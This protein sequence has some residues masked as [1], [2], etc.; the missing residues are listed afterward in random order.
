[1]ELYQYQ[2]RKCSHSFKRNFLILEDAPFACP[3]CGDIQAM[4]AL[5]YATLSPEIGIGR[6]DKRS[7]WGP[8]TELTSKSAGDNAR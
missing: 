3:Q 4:S 8:W 2:C 1:M 7:T 6:A 5:N